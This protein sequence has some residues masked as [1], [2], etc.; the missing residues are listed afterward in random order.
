MSIGRETE[1]D[2]DLEVLESVAKE[3]NYLTERNANTRGWN[4]QNI[5][6]NADLVIK[7]KY[8]EF[9]MGFAKQTDGT[10]MMKADHHAGHVDRELLRITPRYLE[11]LAER[12]S[13]GRFRNPVRE[14]TKTE[15][16]LRFKF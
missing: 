6:P 8:H 11:T 2:F 5:L 7:S 16:I 9:D 12:N 1:C 15:I 3:L 4:G 13:N 14:E 10:V